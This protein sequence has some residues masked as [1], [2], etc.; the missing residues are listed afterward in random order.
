M[1]RRKFIHL[2]AMGTVAHALPAQR[3]S[4]ARPVRLTVQNAPARIEV[5]PDFIGLGYEMSSPARPGLLSVN[6]R[7]YLNTGSPA[8]S[9]R[10]V[11]LRRHCGRPHF[12]MKLQG[13]PN[14]EPD[15]TV[16]THAAIEQAAAFLRAT[17]WQAIWSVNFGSGTLENAI[18]ELRDVSALLGDRLL[19][20]E[21]GNEVEAYSRGRQPHRPDGY[22]YQQYRA[23]MRAGT[24][25]FAA[26]G[27]A[28]ALGGTGYR[29][30]YRLGGIHGR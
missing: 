24:P 28:V 30:K 13:S 11:A 8:R 26:A 17:G 23:G 12:G 1:N 16:L 20:V 5:T 14:M 2:T 10:Y 6:N 7:V 18:A 4:T 3:A 22:T 27:A 29:G 19:A 9:T 25:P 15:D 21:I